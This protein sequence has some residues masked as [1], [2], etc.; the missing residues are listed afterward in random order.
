MTKKYKVLS[1]QQILKFEDEMKRL[2]VSEVARSP[3]G[4]LGQMKKY[5][6]YEDFKNKTASNSNMTWEDK[7]NS[8]IA[9]HLAQYRINPTERRRLSLLAWGYKV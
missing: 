8:F 5:G 3:S 9:R 2:K 6:S 7:R 1:L 4:F